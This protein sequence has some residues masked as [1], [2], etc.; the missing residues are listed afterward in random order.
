MASRETFRPP[1]EPSP[2]FL[3]SGSLGSQLGKYNSK[4]VRIPPGKEWAYTL[5]QKVPDSS[6]K[7]VTEFILSLPHQ[8][9]QKAAE[10]LS[11]LIDGMGDQIWNSRYPEVEISKCI[12]ETKRWLRVTH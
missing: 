1:E 9:R 2:E 3:T 5:I 4:E 8:N 12:E 11:N 10:N 7:T 6:K